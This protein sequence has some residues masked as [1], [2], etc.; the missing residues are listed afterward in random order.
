MK[1]KAKGTNIH[2]TYDLLKDIRTE[3]FVSVPFCPVSITCALFQTPK[4]YKLDVFNHGHLL[5]DMRRRRR[6]S[7]LLAIFSE[8]KSLLIAWIHSHTTDTL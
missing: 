8:N 1:G 7:C 3:V 5:V 6:I 4:L 2:S